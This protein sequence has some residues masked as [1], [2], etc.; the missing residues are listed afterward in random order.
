MADITVTAGNVLPST[1]AEI[2]NE[3]AGETITA[4]QA[5][6]KKAADSRM[7]KTDADDAA[8]DEFYGIALN[9]ASAGQ[10]V[11][12]QKRGSITI[13]GTVVVGTV[14]VLST[15]AGGICP[16]ADLAAEDYVTIV[17]IGTTAATIALQPYTSGVAIPA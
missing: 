10:P 17:G 2:S 11:A 8:T 9:G 13:G 5:L 3:T 16:W 15:T 4:G 7:W 12:V 1:N 14:Y 6:Y